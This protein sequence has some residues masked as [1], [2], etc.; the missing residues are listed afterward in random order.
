[1]LVCKHV[2]S[3]LCFLQWKA[4][5]EELEEE[6]EDE[7][8]AALAAL[9][10]K[11]QREIE[12]HIKYFPSA[13]YISYLSVTYVISLFLLF[14]DAFI[15]LLNCRSGMLS[16]LPVERLERM[17]IFSLWVAIGASPG[18]NFLCWMLG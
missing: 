9:E 10:R 13:Q 3:S 14:C 7:A 1:M 11:R 6:E 12:V 18:D 8:K 4:A 16:K 5:K 17:Q 15:C 2:L